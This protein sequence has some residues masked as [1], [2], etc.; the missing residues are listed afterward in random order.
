M[1]KSNSN[2]SLDSLSSHLSGA[3]MSDYVLELSKAKSSQTLTL[4]RK[5]LQVTV[6]SVLKKL[7]VNK[8][9]VSTFMEI[10]NS[11]NTEQII[12]LSEDI[13]KLCDT[14]PEAISNITNSEEAL[15]SY[16]NLL[17]FSEN[18]NLTKSLLNAFSAIFPYSNEN[19]EVLINCLSLQFY[20][21]FETATPLTILPTIDLIKVVSRYSSYGRNTLLCYSVHEMLSSLAL[22]TADQTIS[23]N[24]CSALESI[25]GNS[26]KVECEI[27]ESFIPNLIQL[28]T[29]PYDQSKSFIMLTMSHI[30]TQMPCAVNKLCLAGVHIAVLQSLQIEF[31]HSSC[32]KLITNLV[33]ADISYVQQMIEN[34]LVDCL[35][36]FMDSEKTAEALL[37]LSILVERLPEIVETLLPKDF[38]ENLIELANCSP[39]AVKKQSIYFIATEIFV[40][41]QNSVEKMIKPEIIELLVE[42]LVSG[43]KEVILRCLQAMGNLTH[44]AICTGNA[45]L[46]ATYLQETDIFKALSELGENRLSAISDRAISLTSKLNTVFHA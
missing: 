13:Q 32:L 35:L 21:L 33:A 41:D 26:E 24:C 7:L 12:K 8:M 15:E 25:F 34:R 40:L 5:C 31:L 42:M 2:S 1:I 19:M 46:Y 44:V 6:S 10:I 9:E 39:F 22:S 16:A 17:M 30:S 37:I 11:N 3:D 38:V 23:V 27:I 36:V 18:E 20:N 29:L 28:L 14:C 45:N 4:R 43:Q